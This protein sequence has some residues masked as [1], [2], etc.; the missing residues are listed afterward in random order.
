V[1]APSLR[2]PDRTYEIH[3]VSELTGLA[4][5][6]L[7]AWERRYEVVRPRR[8]PN[9]YRVYTGEQ[10]AL[11]RA[12]ARLVARGERIGDLAS[13]PAE[14]VLARVEARAGDDSPL[15]ALLGAIRDFDRERLEGLV[16]QQL[17]LRGLAGF[18]AEVVLPLAQLVGDAWAIGQLPVAAEHLASEVV[19]QA[20]KTGLRGARAGGPLFLAGCL[21][22]ER[23]EWGLLAT[24]AQLQDRGWR[25]QYLGADLPIEEMVETSWKLMPDAVG[26]S[27]SDPALVRAALPALMALPPRLP[28]DAIAVLG[29][30]GVEPFARQLQGYGYR[31]GIESLGRAEA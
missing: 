24:L 25:I 13:Q 19:V 9:G 28:P 5:A 31:I 18:A 20:L 3:E 22:T 1:P 15:G 12:Y 8:L 4:P 16:A 11:L 27:S 10:V 23:H 29:G 7:R 6:R 30:A 21:P 14:A 26:L 17:G 2:R